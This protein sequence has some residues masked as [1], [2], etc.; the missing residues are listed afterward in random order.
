MTTS[1]MQKHRLTSKRLER[2]VGKIRSQQA[3]GKPLNR[4]QLIRLLAAW[5]NIGFTASAC[6]LQQVERIFM[7]SKGAVLECGSGVTTILLGILAEQHERYVWT[8]EHNEKWCTH[9]RDVLKRLELKRVLV[10]HAPL[11]NYGE[12]EWYSLPNM[13]L[14]QNFDMVVCDGPPGSIRGGRY[15]LSPVIGDRLHPDCRILLDDTHRRNA[16]K[17]I[18]RWKRELNLCSES[19]G[20]LGSCTELA[21]I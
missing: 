20:A 16:Q 13:P 8:F 2:L 17:L 19:R 4:W 15:G 9:M 6:Y 7:E 12:Y 5:G 10:C 1:I 21:M 3:N 11:R 18:K 14:P